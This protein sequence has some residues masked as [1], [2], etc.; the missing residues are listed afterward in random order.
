M[1]ATLEANVLCPVDNADLINPVP[2][3]HKG[4]DTRLLLYVARYQKVCVTDV[5][6]LA[7]AHYNN[8]KH[9]GT[10][11]HFRYMITSFDSRMCETLHVFHAFTK[12]DIVS[13]FGGGGG[14][15]GE[16]QDNSLG[17]MAVLPKIY[18]RI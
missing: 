2:C 11:S 15:R 1:Y 14:G 18:G 8:V 13:S 3:S 6:V 5:V 9:D 7:I 17:P 16:R 10:G 12:C 4:A